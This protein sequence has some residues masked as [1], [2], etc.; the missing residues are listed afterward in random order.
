MKA[1]SFTQA[2]GMDLVAG[3]STITAEIG[4]ATAITTAN[5]RLVA[6]SIILRR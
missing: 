4:I 3:L 2:A 5:K 1:A 6:A